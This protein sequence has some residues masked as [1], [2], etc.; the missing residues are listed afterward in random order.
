MTLEEYNRLEDRCV[1]SVCS[2]SHYNEL[3]YSAVASKV[4][5]GEN[6]FCPTWSCDGLDKAQPYVRGMPHTFRASRAVDTL[7]GLGSGSEKCLRSHKDLAGLETTRWVPVNTL[8]VRPRGRVILW[9]RLKGANLLVKSASTPVGGGLWLAETFETLGTVRVGD[10]LDGMPISHMA[11]AW[12]E[13]WW[14]PEDWCLATYLLLTGSLRTLGRSVPEIWARPDSLTND[15]RENNVLMCCDLRGSRSHYGVPLGKLARPDRR[16]VVW[17][18][19]ELE[20]RY[21][22]RGCISIEACHVLTV[23]ETVDT[24][25]NS[26]DVAIQS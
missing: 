21:W 15:S 25:L 4:P 8:T 5:R 23:T 11:R 13:S 6:M 20:N 7:I 19:I 3:D 10:Q 24:K 22:N 1:C 26:L 17:T 12:V 14:W 16:Q 18:I 2:A 9:E